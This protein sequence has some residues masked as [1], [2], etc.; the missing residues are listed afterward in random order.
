MPEFI[1]R[2][3]MENLAMLISFGDS[4]RETGTMR[5]TLLRFRMR[6]FLLPSPGDLVQY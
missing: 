3:V 1:Y 2:L 5:R 6:G 4:I